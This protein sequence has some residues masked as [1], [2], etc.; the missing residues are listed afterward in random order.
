MAKI[1]GKILGS[2]KGPKG[3]SGEPKGSPKGP[4]GFSV[5]SLEGRTPPTD[6]QIEAAKKIHS[7]TLVDR[8]AKMKAAGLDVP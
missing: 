4:K 6:E 7:D 3:L 2:P 8:N 5:S 1:F